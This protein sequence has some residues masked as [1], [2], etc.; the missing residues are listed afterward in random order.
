[1]HH[2]PTLETATAYSNEELFGEFTK[3]LLV[4]CRGVFFFGC[5]GVW[6]WPGLLPIP[7]TQNLVRH[8]IL[9]AL[10]VQR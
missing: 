5:L 2:W 9:Q 4:S 3:C 8:R 7:H 10:V 6:P 1:M